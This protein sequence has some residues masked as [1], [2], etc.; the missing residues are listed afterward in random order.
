MRPVEIIRPN[1]LEL[2]KGRHGEILQ[3]DL[4]RL[5]IAGYVT[6]MRKGAEQHWLLVLYDGHLVDK[7]YQS[8]EEEVRHYYGV[9]YV[10][11]LRHSLRPRLDSRITT[12]LYQ[13]VHVP[14]P[15]LSHQQPWS[16]YPSPSGGDVIMPAVLYGQ[17]LPYTEISEPPIVS[18]ERFLLTP[19]T[20][21]PN[22]PESVVS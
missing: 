21:N 10:P 6:V 9:T 8:V 7:P 17:T 15:H 14:D 11:S 2:S 13:T 3:I 18:L 16:R 12:S 20:S 5:S 1:C 22:T 19:T 4:G